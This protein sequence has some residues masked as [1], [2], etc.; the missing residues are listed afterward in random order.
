MGKW[1][2]AVILAVGLV[3]RI[4]ALGQ[5][6]VGFTPDEASFGYDA[7]SLLKTGKDQ[8]GSSWPISF[9]SFGDFKLP[10]YTYLTIPSVAVFGLNEFAVRLP[11]AVIGILAILATYLASGVLFKDKR[12][13][14]LAALLLAIS[15]WHLSLSRGA[16]EANLTVCFM[17][18]GV[19]AFYKGLGDRKWLVVSA[20]I[21]GINLFTYHS[22][23]LVTP[24]ILFILFLVN[25]RELGAKKFKDIR[26][27]VLQNWLPVVIFGSLLALALST[28]FTGSG[29]RAVDITIFNPTDRWESVFDTRYGVVFGGLPY[30]LAVFFHNKIFTLISQ[31]IVAYTTYISPQFLFTQGAGEWTYGM[32]AGWGVLYLVEILFVLASLWFLAKEGFGKSRLLT[33]LVCWILVGFI[34]AALTKGPGY[35]GNRAAVVMPAIQIFSAFGAVLLFDF[36]AKRIH[37]YLLLFFYSF[38]LLVSLIFFLESYR[39]VAPRLG[40]GG[41]LYGRKEAFVYIKQNENKYKEIIVSRNLSEPQIYV[42]FYT[43]YDP[44]AYQKASQDWLRYKDIGVPFVD[45]LGEYYL[46]KYIFKNINYMDDS[47]IPSVLIVGKPSEF[48]QDIVPTYLI[49]YPDQLPD[50]YIVDPS[51]VGVIKINE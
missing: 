42:A 47:K 30:N 16:F 3:L 23:R 39:F 2:L 50:I 13:A 29:A 41:M 6:P 11:S 10:V 51:N 4:W 27:V 26:R 1:I 9:R 28:I 44:L 33:F 46:G 12:I 14:L 43:K 7:Y 17:A 45:Q 49:R 20:L 24:F 19:W 31:F 15:P 40:A 25:R 8:W 35:A 48:P 32:V 37:E 21:L 18:L 34:P 38:V 22:A 5:L 36:L